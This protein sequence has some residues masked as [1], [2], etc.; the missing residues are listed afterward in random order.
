MSLLA[1][2]GLSHSYRSRPLLGPARTHEALSDISL[3]I[4]EGETV[5]LL[6]RS[7]CGKSTLARLI[8]GLERPT[9]GEI[10]FRGTPLAAARGAARLKMRRAVQMVFQDSP[11]ATNPRH[12]V[13][14]IVAEPLRHLTRLDRK[15]RE[16]RVAELLDLVELPPRTAGMRPGQLSGGQLQRVCIARALAPEPRLVILDEA[17]SNLDLHLQASTLAFLGDIRRQSGIACLFITHDLRLVNR[18][19][20]RVLV[21]DRGR[22][23][24]E[25]PSGE[26]ATL[27]HPAS[28]ALREAILPPFPG[29][30]A[31]SKAVTPPENPRE[32]PTAPVEADAAPSPIPVP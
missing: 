11:D 14:R 27:S 5:A 9:E 20:D 26:L 13:G 28:R 21:M 12:T 32:S 7:G 24:E 15:D 6:G 3:E 31:A 1:A 8:S 10:L 29:R 19:A 17:V 30:P 16:A 4:A 25:A 2:R 23:V 18:F 22:I